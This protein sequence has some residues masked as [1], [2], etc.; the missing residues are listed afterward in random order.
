MRENIVFLRE[1]Q[2][3]F[4]I[5]SLKKRRELFTRGLEREIQPSCNKEQRGR[6][7]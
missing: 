2:D 7:K 4:A 6:L 3:E 5:E 1:A